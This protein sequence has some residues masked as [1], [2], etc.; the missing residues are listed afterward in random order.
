MQTPNILI[1][2]DEV[3]TRTTLKSLFEAEG[4]NV[5]EAE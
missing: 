5:F 1:V 3:V 2:E 4:Y